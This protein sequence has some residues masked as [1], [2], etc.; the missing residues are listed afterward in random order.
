MNRTL[1]AIG[2]LGI[3]AGLMYL[4]DPAEGR[5]RRARV[6][7]MAV[8]YSRAAASVAG[9]TSRDV[10]H[11]LTGVAARTVGRLVVPDVTPED[12][13]L[14][15]RVRARVGRLVSHPHAIEVHA[16]NGTVTVSGPVF[17]SEVST[18]LNGIGDV[19]G[20]SEVEN[21]L[22][23]YARAD[24]V[25]ALQGPGPRESHWIP[26]GLRHWTPTTRLLAT[27]AGLVLVAIS[28]PERGARRTASGMLGLQLL[29]HAVGRRA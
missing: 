19:A 26:E 20:V 15:A 23:P 16:S 13:V 11:R 1:A 14:V 5:R 25:S 22:K 2:S 18:L 10:Q 27:V 3:G 28:T 6:R 7:D 24:K 29:E 12:D 17:E 21:Q 9:S 8:H 4:A